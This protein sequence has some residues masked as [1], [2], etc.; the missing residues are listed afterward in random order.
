MNIPE[1]KKVHL[2]TLKLKAG[3]SAWW[4]QIEVNR[5]RNGKKHIASWEKMKKLMKT[6]FLPPNYEETL[7][8]HYQNCQQ[9]TRIVV[10]Y[11]KQFH[12]FGARTG[13]LEN[14]LVCWRMNNTSL[15]D[16]LVD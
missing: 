6:W 9:R 15:S 10:D 14:E 2:V 5:R 8:N 3:A 11:I 1:M 7:Y 4:E 16:L 12:Q 13:L